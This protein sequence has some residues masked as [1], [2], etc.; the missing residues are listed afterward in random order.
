MAKGNIYSRLPV[1]L[2]GRDGPIA[3]GKG[4]VRGG[5]LYNVKLTAEEVY[6]SRPFG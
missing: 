1:V 3:F 2:G 4:R 6:L 5:D